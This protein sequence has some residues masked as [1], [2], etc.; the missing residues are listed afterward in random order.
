MGIGMV[1]YIVCSHLLYTRCSCLGQCS[2]YHMHWPLGQ[3]RPEFTTCNLVM[4]TLR[5]S[6]RKYISAAGCGD[7]GRGNL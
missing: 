7:G 1:Y 5:L 2:V 4:R 6:E 3:R